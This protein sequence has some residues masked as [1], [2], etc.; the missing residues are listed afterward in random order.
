MIGGHL[1]HQSIAGGGIVTTV[2]GID[3][4]VDALLT[5]QEAGGTLTATGAE[6]TLYGEDAPIGCAEQVCMFVSLDDMAG[7]DTTV[8][9]AYSRIAPGGGYE[10]WHYASYAGADG[11][12]TDGKTAVVIDLKPNRFGWKVTLEQTAGVNAD[13]A[14]EFFGRQ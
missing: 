2:D 9:R 4:A 8:L 6:Q 13:Y 3:A 12:L 11:G 1:T 5:L 14:W 10:L 7:G